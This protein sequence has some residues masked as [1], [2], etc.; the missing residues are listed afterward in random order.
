LPA[1][2]LPLA[3]VAGHRVS[4][5][6]GTGSVG[7][8]VGEGPH[9]QRHRHT[10]RGTYTQTEAHTH[11]NRHI[12][13]NRGTYTQTEAQLLPEE[14]TVGEMIFFFLDVGIT[15]LFTLELVMNIFSHRSHHLIQTH[16][17]I[18]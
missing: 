2:A 10:N 6:W 9:T 17:I 5:P 14:G 16:H 18:E 13:T 11:N 1:H 4:R 12:H 15:S 3:S 8:S 7:D